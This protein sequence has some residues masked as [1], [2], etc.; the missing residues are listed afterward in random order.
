MKCISL[1]NPWA[2]LMAINA[3]RNETRSWPTA[4][5][6]E[7]AIHA[8]KKWN[9]DLRDVCAMPPFVGVLGEFLRSTA[10]DISVYTREYMPF[11]AIV[12]VVDLVDC[13]QITEKNL[14]DGNELDF[15][16]Y[17]ADRFMWQTENAK[18]LRL[19]IPFRGQQGL[20]ALPDEIATRVRQ[21]WCVK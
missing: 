3:K 10:H 16:D 4:Y 14:P 19:P 8:A 9:N 5:R 15:G 21:A 17:R 18:R 7:L 11:G 12:A 1:W 20:F 6:G 13:V 2:F